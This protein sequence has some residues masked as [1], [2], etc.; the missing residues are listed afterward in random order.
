[1]LLHDIGKFGGRSR[2]RTRFHFAGHEALS[3]QIIRSELDLSRFDLTPAQIEYIARTAEDHFVLGLVRKRAREE[4]R[5]DSAF[6]QS[7]RFAE[8]ARRIKEEHPD[9]FVETGVLFLGDSLAKLNPAE[10]PELAA[11]Q[12]DIN[13]E[14]AHRYFELVLRGE[15]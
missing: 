8:I 3:G 10:G 5:Y 9:D 11:A 2:G 15:P 13:I 6:V 14:V 7:E 4:G 1:V 12:Y